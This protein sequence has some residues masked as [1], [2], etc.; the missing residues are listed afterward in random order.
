MVLARASGADASVAATAAICTTAIE[1]VPLL[2]LAIALASML[3]DPRTKRALRAMTTSLAGGRTKAHFWLGVVLAVSALSGSVG[4]TSFA[5]SHTAIASSTQVVALVTMGSMAASFF[6]LAAVAFR[7]GPALAA[8]V[9]PIE[10]RTALLSRHATPAVV[11]AWVALAPALVL[12]PRSLLV[13]PIAAVGGFVLGA[14]GFPRAS[15]RS[16]IAALLVCATAYAAFGSIA[17]NARHELLA[18]APLA[19]RIVRTARAFVDR[20]RDG[21]SPILAG[22]D[23]DDSDPHIHPGAHDIPGNGIDENCTGADATPYVRAEEP[24]HARPAA[25]PTRPNIML[26]QLD[27]MRPDHL[28]FAGYPRATSPRLDRFQKSATWFRRAYT[29]APSTRWA[30]PAVFT[31]GE[32][33]QIPLTRAPGKD[34]A[35]LEGMP[36]FADRLAPLAYERGGFPIAYVTEHFAGLGRGFATWRSASSA[37]LPEPTTDAALEWLATRDATR[38]F[39]LFVHY[40][41]THDPYLPTPARPFGSTE[42]DRYDSGAARCDGEAG[43]LFDALDRRSDADHTV[44][45]VFSDHGELFGEHG[46]TQHGNSLFESDVR[47]LLL[48][49]F[50]GMTPRTVDVPVSLVDIYATVLTLAGFDPPDDGPAWDLLPFAAGEAVPGAEHR[51]IFLANGIAMPGR[52]MSRAIVV[53]DAKYVRDLESGAEALYD[54]RTDPDERVDLALREP[55]RRD[56]LRERLESWLSATA[57]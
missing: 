23:C 12:L 13:S 56:A 45:I 28:H 57:R 10:R 37:S 48:A 5:V 7:V 30:M 50:P 40:A 31:G 15:R 22:G 54:L 2:A 52:E 41:C 44:V 34:T 16:A 43:R 42:M 27:A 14:C 53:D 8:A 9:A 25:I 20:D 4:I 49:R 3:D 11:T 32:I 26:V 35:L 38:P 21:Y 55:A 6:A 29:P 51:P 17:A 33:E 24:A 46:F 19:G 36:T 18:H 39:L 47:V 1:A